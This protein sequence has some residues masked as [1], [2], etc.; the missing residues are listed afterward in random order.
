MFLFLLK[1]DK[2]SKKLNKLHVLYNKEAE[3]FIYIHIEILKAFI[4]KRNSIE[5]TYLLVK[6]KIIKNNTK[7]KS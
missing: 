4:K 5:T 7:N 2:I 3:M 6:I 1:C